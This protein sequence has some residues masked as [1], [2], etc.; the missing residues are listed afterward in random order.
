MTWTAPEVTRTSGS[1]VADERE[2]LE[3]FLAYYR[4]TLL[5][6]CAGLT[7][8][9]LAEQTVQPSNLTLLGLLRHMAKVERTWFRD[10]FA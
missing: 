5:T 7:G 4:N 10:R 6:K 9:Q 1:L 2:T 8:D 3:G